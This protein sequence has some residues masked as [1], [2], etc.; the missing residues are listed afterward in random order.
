M[1]HKYLLEV[2]SENEI[3]FP[4]NQD[5]AAYWDLGKCIRF[6]FNLPD[7]SLFTSGHSLKG[8]SRECFGIEFQN[9]LYHLDDNFS[10]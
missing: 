10:N 5:K 3:P 1:S 6:H 2:F 9:G 7:V 8:T 4:F